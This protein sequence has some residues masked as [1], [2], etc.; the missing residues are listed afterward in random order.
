VWARP[1]DRKLQSLD[2]LNPTVLSPIAAETPTTRRQQCW[3]SCSCL[4][5]RENV[6]KRS[7]GSRFCLS[8]IHRPPNGCGT[9]ETSRLNNVHQEFTSHDDANKLSICIIYAARVEAL[10]CMSDCRQAMQ[11]DV[12]RM[13]VYSAPDDKCQVN[14]SGLFF[15]SSS[16][17]SL[18]AR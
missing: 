2:R 12:N 4:S 8:I 16:V 14:V 17:M 10:I 7:A 5:S 18:S 9:F 1:N 15:A 13:K 11:K 6:N 3:F